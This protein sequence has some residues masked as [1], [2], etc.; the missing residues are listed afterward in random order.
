MLTQ[1]RVK[2]LFNYNPENGELIWIK[3]SAPQAN[4]VKVGMIAGCVN[5]SSGYRTILY[6]RKTYQASRIIF[7][8]MTGSFPKNNIDHI[9]G[10]KTD[11]RW[12]N[13]REV[14]TTENNRNKRIHK[15]NTSGTMGVYFRKNRDTWIAEI[16]SNSKM[17][18]LGSFK[19]KADA[20][21]ARKEA[22]KIYGYHQNHGRK[23]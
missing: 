5:K 15:N 2:E 17:I 20:I 7:M 9:N 8:Y 1:E 10:V 13:L 19:N 14:T 4:T 16:C 18:R 21:K 12:V 23:N 11:N 22:E 6:N 3:K